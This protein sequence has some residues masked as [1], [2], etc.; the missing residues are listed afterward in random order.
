MKTRLRVLGLAAA[1]SGL[2]SAAFAV[3]PTPAPAQPPTMSA[4]A[5]KMNVVVGS[6]AK[7]VTG[8]PVQKD[9]KVILRNLDALI[10]ALEKECQ[11][12]KGGMAKNRPNRPAPDS[13]IHGGTGGIGDLVEPGKGDKDWTKLTPRERDRILQS[14]SEGFPPEYRT[15]LERY[16]RRLAEEKTTK[17]GAEA[18]DAKADAD[19]E[20]DAP[21]IR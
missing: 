19:A 10:A 17:P 2:S 20:A 11:A 8:E 14:M 7:T 9:Q 15:V 18:A 6:L 4:I 1:V 3:G 5:G 16:Y 13:N 12:C 21:D